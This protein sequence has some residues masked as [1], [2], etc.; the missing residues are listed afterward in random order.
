MPPDKTKSRDRERVHRGNVLYHSLWICWKDL[1]EFSRSR[2]R[3]VMLV[4]MPLFMMAMVGFIFPSN[5][6]IKDQPV[7][8]A[9]LDNGYTFNYTSNETQNETNPNGT[10]LFLNMSL[11]LIEHLQIL[12]NQ[13]GM[14]KLSSAGSFDE[15]R[16]RA[17]SCLP[18]SSSPRTSQWILYQEDRDLLKSLQTSPTPSFLLQ[19]RQ[20]L[21]RLSKR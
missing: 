15:I 4:I 6:T 16:E 8:I 21:Q 5:N 17:G 3:V 14:M 19:C 20:S 7:A 9:N 12:N 18:E 2:M 1:V 10:E 13:T 11:I